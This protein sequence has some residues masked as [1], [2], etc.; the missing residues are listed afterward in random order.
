MQIVNEAKF[1]N[2]TFLLVLFTDAAAAA[3][4]VFGT[5]IVLLT[6]MYASL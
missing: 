5:V 6:G 4:A 3:A 1:L 2:I